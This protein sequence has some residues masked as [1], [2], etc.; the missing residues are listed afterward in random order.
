MS[1]LVNGMASATALHG[2][3]YLEGKLDESTYSEEERIILK[4]LKKL[5]ETTE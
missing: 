2:Y 4:E 5:K 1:G 3:E